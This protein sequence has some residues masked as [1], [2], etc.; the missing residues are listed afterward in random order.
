MAK[1]LQIH[2]PNYAKEELEGKRAAALWHI[3]FPED[4]EGL[5]R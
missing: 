3:F 2:F 4:Y 5:K 1:F